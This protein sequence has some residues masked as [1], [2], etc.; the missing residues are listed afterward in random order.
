M[1]AWF[2]HH[3]RQ[4]LPWQKQRTAYRVWLAEIML[5]QT[6][7][8]TVIPYYQRFLDRFPDL[9]SLA[10][11][12]QDEVLALW[13]GLGYYA[14]ARNLYRTAGIV[15]DDHDGELPMDPVVLESLPGIGTSTARAIVSQVTDQPLAILDGNVK[16]VL[17]RH[18]G[19]EGWPGKSAVLRQLW[20]EAEQ[21]VPPAR[22]ADYTQASM[23]L[24]AL[25]CTRHNPDCRMCPVN[26]D[27]F[28]Y[29]ENRVD[30]LPTPRPRRNRPQK[31]CVMVIR[32]DDAGAVLLE[33]R[34]PTG[35]WGGLWCLPMAD[36]LAEL[37]LSN[38]SVQK[39]EPV[40]HGFTH[41]RLRIQPVIHRAAE[42]DTVQSPDRW[43]KFSA[44]E[45]AVLGLPGP[46][47]DILQTIEEMR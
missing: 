3:G 31:S 47:R 15:V 35:I 11:A 33:R 40:D 18:A 9:G 7:V 37:G 28:A 41:F 32:L 14:R 17:A 39:L 6:Q 38:A 22:G 21:R 1:L 10:A 45:W 24:G 16:R 43:K 2:D 12:H 29:R 4:D 26:G 5:Q 30:E 23:D 36:S 46:V 8:A 13:S 42:P 25:V 27:C 44:A 20:N 19:I 34:P